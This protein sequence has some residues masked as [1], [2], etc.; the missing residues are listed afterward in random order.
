M[1]PRIGSRPW[2]LSRL[3]SGATTWLAVPDGRA[4]AAFMQ[5]IAADIS[6]LGLS[7]QFTQALYIAVNPRTLAV[8]ELISVTRTDSHTG[9]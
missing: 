5:Q 6:R 8:H 1:T 9:D 4:N 3:G 2:I 7:G